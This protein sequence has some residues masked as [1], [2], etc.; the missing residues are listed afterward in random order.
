MLVKWPYPIPGMIESARRELPT[1]MLPPMSS[2]LAIEYADACPVP[3][4]RAPPAI[5]STPTC[6]ASAVCDGTPVVLHATEVS[7]TP[8]DDH[9][10]QS[11]LDERYAPVTETDVVDEP[12]RW[13]IDNPT[14]W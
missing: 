9:P 12:I 7:D 3:E 13:W 10:E 4:N 14:L 11:Q 2:E 8:P 6:P 5:I 1:G